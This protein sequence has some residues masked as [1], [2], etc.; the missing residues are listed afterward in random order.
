LCGALEFSENLSKSGT[1]PIIG[2]QI[3]F[4]FKDIIG[5][6]PLIAT[7]EK[8]YQNII[9]FS[10]NSY[11]KNND[12]DEPHCNFNDVLSTV[13][14][15]IILSGTINGLIG[16][17]FVKGRI[18]EIE[19]I[20]LNLKKKFKNNFYIEIQRHGDE[21]EKTFEQFNLNLSKKI[22]IPIIAT[23]EVFY[24]SKD[25]HDAHDALICIGNKTYLNEKNRVKYS[26]NHYLKS[27]NEM[28]KIFSDLPEALENN[29]NLIYK[30][31]FK[32]SFSKPGITKYKF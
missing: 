11:L 6:L 3:N 15:I 4:K 32:P 30:C 25:M 10:S 29:Y 23:N 17:L 9:E 2:T 7:S 22:D 27:D 21:N 24:I 14:D 1:Q 12:K 31:N 8:G 18:E 5:L 16:K 28:E 13:N 26:N 20:Y 19:E